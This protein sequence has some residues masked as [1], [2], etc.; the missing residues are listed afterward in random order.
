MKDEDVTRHIA[1]QLTE[2]VIEA[3]EVFGRLGLVP[4]VCPEFPEGG[5]A[6][7]SKIK[8]EELMTLNF[9]FIASEKND[10]Y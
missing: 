6:A 4:E 9:S 10:E 7:V 3:H 5:I 8:D 1:E 2:K